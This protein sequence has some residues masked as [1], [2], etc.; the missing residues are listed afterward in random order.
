M[1]YQVII[2]VGYDC[3]G[4]GDSVDNRRV[5]STA[6]NVKRLGGIFLSKNIFYIYVVLF[7]IYFGINYVIN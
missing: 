7:F 4:Y 2:N 6:T 3:F 5:R 1:V